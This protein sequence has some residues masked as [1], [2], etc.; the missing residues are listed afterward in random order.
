[1]ARQPINQHEGSAT[2]PDGGLWSIGLGATL[3]FALVAACS[4]PAPAVVSAGDV[5]AVDTQDGKNADSTG[6]V[7]VWQL[8]CT[9]PQTKGCPC[10]IGS[11]ECCV[12][13]SQ[14]LSCGHWQDPPVW[15]ASSDCCRDPNPACNGVNPIT[16]PGWCNGKAP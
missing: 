12:T 11:A 16:Q 13:Q 5:T 2:R 15:M 1:M 6:E 4:S 8:D 9:L 14:G 7:D 10:T 3:V